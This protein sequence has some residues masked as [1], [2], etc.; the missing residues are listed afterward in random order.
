MI[1]HKASVVDK[2]K[3]FKT[4]VLCLSRS[5]VFPQKYLTCVHTCKHGNI[6]F[7]TTKVMHLLMSSDMLTLK[8]RAGAD[9][10]DST[11]SVSILAVTTA[12]LKRCSTGIIWVPDALILPLFHYSKMIYVPGCCLAKTRLQRKRS[13]SS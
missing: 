7:P 1:K 6:I 9:P 11:M 4:H 12:P 13:L 3:L 5:C 10:R 8:L 2:S